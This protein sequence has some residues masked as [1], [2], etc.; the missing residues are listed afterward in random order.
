MTE[1]CLYTS[2]PTQKKPG[3][4][5]LIREIKRLRSENL[6]LHNSISLLKSDLHNASQSRQEADVAYK[7]I[8]EQLTHRNQLLEL[9]LMDKQDEIE[10]L[11]RSSSYTLPHHFHDETFHGDTNDHFYS[12]DDD[13]ED[14]DE[15]E[16]FTSF[17]PSYF[18][19]AILSK[20]T[21][22]RVRL[23]LDDYILKYDA[24][25]RDLSGV[26][27]SALLDWIQSKITTDKKV[28]KVFMTTI[29]SG[30]AGFW[31]EILSYFAHDAQAQYHLLKD[32]EQRSAMIA[33]HFHHLLLMLYKHHIV[34]D[35]ATLLWWRDP[36]DNDMSRKMRDTTLKFVNW[37]QD[38]EDEDEDSEEEEE[39][40][41]EI[42][43][44]DDDINVHFQHDFI[45]FEDM[46]LPAEDPSTSGEDTDDTMPESHSFHLLTSLFI[47]SEYCI[48]AFTTTTT[49]T[50]TNN[51]RSTSF[52]NKLLTKCSCKYMSQQQP[53]VVEK[54]EKS[55][56]I[57]M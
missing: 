30:I 15:L 56:R 17:I 3:H 44:D 25:Q 8:Y 43:Y 20:L 26:L 21:S 45:H 32:I 28:S 39:E 5:S 40:V 38:S 7:K 14:Q 49:T 1:T 42:E 37:I 29:Q 35:E 50:T 51:N 52:E 16:P 57:A 48:C 18:H 22:A 41:E 4:Y 34:D 54:K 2:P 11:K 36:C 46:D 9:E 23:E 55:V 19:Q 13:E 53:V 27:A 10:A 47:N 31:Q 12:D 6:S 33:D 24:S